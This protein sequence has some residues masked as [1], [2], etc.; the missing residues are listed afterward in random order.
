MRK[1][2]FLFDDIIIYL[3]NNTAGIHHVEPERDQ[4]EIIL[5]LTPEMLRYRRRTRTEDDFQFDSAPGWAMPNC[6]IT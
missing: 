2:I 3:C 4:T 6:T 5:L 1:T